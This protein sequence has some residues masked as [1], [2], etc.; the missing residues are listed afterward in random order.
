MRAIL[1]QAMKLYHT[2]SILHQAMKMTIKPVRSRKLMNLSK[3]KEA[4]AEKDGKEENF[5]FIEKRV[6]MKTRIVTRRG[7]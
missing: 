7:I 5:K 4:K 3:E 2:T 1:H 6:Q